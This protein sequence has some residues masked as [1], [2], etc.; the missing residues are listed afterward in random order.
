M[1][2]DSGDVLDGAGLAS[3]VEGG[4]DSGVVREVGG[5]GGGGGDG[6]AREEGGGGGGGGDG[7]TTGVGGGGGGGGEFGMVGE[8]GGGGG[9]GVLGMDWIETL[10]VPAPEGRVGTVAEEGDIEACTQPEYRTF[11]I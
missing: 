2:L 9:G 4:E 11:V 8:G 6:E 10:A 3:G 1:G 7:E 5:G